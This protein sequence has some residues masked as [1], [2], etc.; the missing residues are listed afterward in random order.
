[1]KTMTKEETK[2]FKHYL[3]VGALLEFIEKHNI[4]HTALILAQRVEDFYY[5]K[6]GW[7][8]YTKEGEECAYL[9]RMNQ[10]L[11]PAFHSSEEEIAKAREQYHPVWCPVIYEDD[12]DDFLFLDLHY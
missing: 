5:E 12:K 7:R 1:M 11:D 10:H 6:H 9:R 8:S 4:P 3:T 2:G